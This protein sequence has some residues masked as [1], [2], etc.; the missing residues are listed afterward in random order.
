MRLKIQFAAGLEKELFEVKSQ[1]C[2][3]EC[4]IK[5]NEENIFAYIVCLN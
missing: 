5:D 2:R 3:A 1:L 4:I